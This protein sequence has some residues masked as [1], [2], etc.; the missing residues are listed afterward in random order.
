MSQTCTLDVLMHLPCSVFSHRQLE[1]FIWLLKVNNID[2]VPSVNSMQELNAMLQK[3]CGI[4]SIPYDGALGKYYVNSLAQ[5]IAQACQGQQ[6][7][8][9]IPAEQTTPM[10]WINS[11]DYFLHEPAMLTDG[12]FCTVLFAKC[13][14]LAA[15]S[16]PSS[17]Y[18]RVIQHETEVSQD[19]FMLNLTDLQIDYNLYNV[20]PPSSITEI[21]DPVQG[22]LTGWT[23]TDPAVGNPWRVQAKGS[24]VYAFPI[25]LYCDDT[26]GNLSKKWNEHNSFL[27]T[28]VGLPRKQAQKEF[29]IHFLSTSN[30]RPPLEML[31]GISIGPARDGI[32]AWDCHAQELVL[33]IPTVLALLGNNPM[34]SEFACHIG[35]KGKYFCR[36]CWVKGSDALDKP[37]ERLVGAK[38]LVVAGESDVESQV[39]SDAASDRSK[40]SGSEAG[41]KKN[42]RGSMTQH[43]KAFVK[44]GR[45]RTKEET[46]GQLWFYFEQATTLNT[47]TRV[48]EMCTASSIKDTFQLV[49][50]EKL[51][52]SYQ[53]KQGKQARQAALDAQRQELPENTSSPVW[54]INGLDPHRDTPVEILHVILLRFVKYMWQ[55]LV[56]NQLKDKI[57]LKALLV[58]RL[59]SFD[60]IL[61]LS[62]VGR[63]FRAIAQA[64]PFVAYDLVSKDC[65]A[66]WVTLSKL[67]PLIWQPSKSFRTALL[68]SEINHF[69]TCATRWTTRWFN[70]PKF[71][72]FLHLPEHIRHFWP[73]IL[74]ATEVFK[75]FNTIIRAK[76]VHSNRHAPSRDVAQAFVQGN[77]IRHLLSGG[78]FMQ[79]AV[80]VAMPHLSPDKHHWT[81]A[82]P[83]PFSLVSSPN[84]VTQYLGLKNKKCG[85]RASIK[86]N[87]AVYLNNG[88]LCELSQFVIAKPP[89]ETTTF[90]ARVKEI[91]QLKDSPNDHSH[92]PSAVLLQSV[93][94]G[95]QPDPSY[96]MPAIELQD[97]W[98]VIRLTDMLCTVNMQHNCTVHGCSPSGF[99]WIYQEHQATE[100]TRPAI[101][102]AAPVD[103]LMLNTAQMRDMA[104]L[105]PFH[106]NSPDLDTNT[107]IEASI[108]HKFDQRKAAAVEAAAAASGVSM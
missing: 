15:V 76:S 57:D 25:W 6:W 11:R 106:I 71:Y 81:V 17:Q 50:L 4:Q 85:T 52:G 45:P 92:R 72:I 38:D 23:L 104:N 100:N 12:T 35:L 99:W 24:P 98:S 30:I 48:K 21:F 63:D 36:A 67:I 103:D 66:T 108:V 83:G 13:W 101:V 96:G 107:I 44:I 77:R 5:I 70:K 29:N 60:V 54:R 68:T 86:T 105:Q 59:N 88:D 65:L 95:S 75:S 41:I 80:T 94:L 62:L 34:Q 89:N 87:S 53:R 90:I 27:F 28:P 46:T 9:E 19:K 43:I 3:L 82:G 64:A 47:K 16:T 18:W 91:L 22:V 10:A 58:T 78:A 40:G 7:L 8:H 32:C 33:M 69:L 2:D 42:P 26:S 1:L 14:D 102:H 56:Q 93:I 79:P 31:D 73:A 39:D 84:T 20:P 97:R 51:F 37:G 74:F 55:D 49:F 61:W